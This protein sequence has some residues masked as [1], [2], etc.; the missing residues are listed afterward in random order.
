MLK[1]KTKIELFDAATG[2]KVAERVDQNLVTNAIKNM[3]GFGSELLMS[4]VNL[5]GMLNSMTPLYPTFLRGVLLW[6][7]A[8]PENP[9]II[10][11]PPGV[12]C[13]GHAGG[14]YSGAK[15]TRG[16]L[17][18]NET[19]VLEN[20]VRMVWD[21]PTDKANGSIRAVSLTSVMGGD[22][23]W[24]TEAE[25]GNSFQLSI[26]SGSFGTQ[27]I[28]NTPNSSIYVGE[29]RR[30]VQTY[31]SNL[32][33]G[34]L[35]VIEQ[36]FANPRQI[37]ILDKAGNLHHDH[38]TE[39]LFTIQTDTDFM[40]FS[41]TSLV[42]ENNIFSSV[43]LTNNRNVRVI[44]IDLIS[45]TIV[46]DISFTLSENVN[47]LSHA[48]WKNHLYCSSTARGGIC[49]FNTDGQFVERVLNSTTT[50]RFSRFD[51]YL[52][53]RVDSIG[54]P[55]SF[56]TDGENHFLIPFANT[57]SPTQYFSGTSSFKPPLFV[58]HRDIVGN[59]SNNPLIQ[60]VTPYLATINN[61]S[62]PVSK[63]SLNTMKVTYELTQE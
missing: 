15:T 38:A 19:Q 62:S 41:G 46:G 57:G 54:H 12:K 36:T 58:N 5:S 55:P 43:R 27:T 53:V 17:N 25:S 16:T 56:L 44:S 63:N 1:G 4:G 31:V 33:G 22:M 18:L 51:K 8:I 37:G 52:Y 34:Q 47:N 9:D 21:F 13:V 49:K 11:A 40:S 20:G 39:T 32:G 28:R 50:S 10:F 35:G 3:L 6:D 26:A 61:L 45:K 14:G 2:E 23:G 59:G 29:L 48:F 30:G 24:F 7:S 42:D 60:Y